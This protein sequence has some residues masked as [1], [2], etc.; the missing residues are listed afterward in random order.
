MA[1]TR[2]QDEERQR[3]V[4]DSCVVWLVEDDLEDAQLIA[5]AFQETRPAARVVHLRDAEY[6]L[7]CLHGQPERKPSLVLLALNPP[8]PNAF[9]FLEVIKTDETLKTI[10][11][12]ALA[13]SR[14]ECDVQVGYDLG[15]AGYVVKPKDRARLR[16]EM[17][18]I[19]AYW[20]QS[21][22]PRTP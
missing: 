1:N 8:V 9:H 12:V 16:E 19:R 10:P 3:T 2:L 11:V 6:A 17:A 20:T 5:Q 22:M 14:V 18:V 15:L 21:L 7:R 4:S 13:K